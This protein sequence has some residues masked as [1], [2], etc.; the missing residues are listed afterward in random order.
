VCAPIARR[1]SGGFIFRRLICLDR[2]K[3]E[4]QARSGVFDRRDF[5]GI[6]H[7][8]R[9]VPSGK[10][11]Q[12]RDQFVEQ[13]NAFAGDLN[14]EIR[15]AGEIAARTSDAFHE[16]ECH[17]L[18]DEAADYRDRRGQRFDGSSSGRRRRKDQIRSEGDDLS[19]ERRQLVELAVGV[20]ALDDQVLPLDISEFREFGEEGLP[21]E[22]VPV[23]A[24]TALEDAEAFWRSL[25][26]KRNR[27]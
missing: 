15:H 3:L 5:D 22:S 1:R 20:A 16:P 9:V 10:P 26:P 14:A 19:S 25:R 2:Q 21:R 27:P 8:F 4:T 17:R 6:A 23:L 24:C 11:L 13:L 18:V 7:G 12:T